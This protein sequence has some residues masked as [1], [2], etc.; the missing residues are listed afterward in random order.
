VVVYGAWRRQSSWNRAGHR[1]SQ[2]HSVGEI[3][4][5]LEGV[6]PHGPRHIGSVLKV[7]R[8]G[9]RAVHDAMLRPID[10]INAAPKPIVSL[11]RAIGLDVRPH[12]S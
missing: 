9:R 1:R 12:R 8:V 4:V 11:L 6:V 3:V 10:T 7:G 5:L 2:R